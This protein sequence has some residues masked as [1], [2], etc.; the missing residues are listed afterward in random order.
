MPLP[1]GGIRRAASVPSQVSRFSGNLTPFFA[2][3]AQQ[4]HPAF[5]RRKIRAA[6]EVEPGRV[7]GR[8]HRSGGHDHDARHSIDGL[9]GI[10]KSDRPKIACKAR[11]HRGNRD[12]ERANGRI[13]TFALPPPHRWARR[14][15]VHDFPGKARTDSPPELQYL[16]AALRA[17]PAA[18]GCRRA[19][20]PDAVSQTPE[21][22]ALQRL[23]AATHERQTG[24][25]H[26][27]SR[28]N[29]LRPTRAA[30]ALPL[31]CQENEI[32]RISME[33]Q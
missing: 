19:P 2:K 31:M 20:P 7:Q 27:Q 6:V 16:P 22:D 33:R 30:V 25:A 3:D 18:S 26:E 15:R 28:G 23:Q 4:R 21:V 10:T 11:R 12:H 13:S 9:P 5:R 24:C 14:A 29:G 8:S 17:S 32:I 1:G